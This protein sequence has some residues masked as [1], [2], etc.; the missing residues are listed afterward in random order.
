MVR[1]ILLLV[2]TA[3]LAVGAAAS[4][5]TGKPKVPPGRDPGG[6]AVA[7]F[8]TGI[9][10]TLPPVAARLARDG[11][12]EPIAWDFEDNDN[13]PFDKA[14]GGAP[15]NWGGDATAVASAL[16]S[17]T[18][19]TRLILVRVDP[20]DPISI[21][22]AVVFLSR[23][24]ARLAL[25]PMWSP[26]QQD[27]EPFRQAA[28]HFRNILFIVPAA[29]GPEPVYPAGL[30]LDNLLAVSGAAPARDSAGFGGAMQQL[31]GARLAVVAA[32]AAAAALLGREPGLGAAAL[33][34]RLVASE[35]GT[36]WRIGK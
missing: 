15:V 27:W 34:Q 19:G 23:T 21:G 16:L 32:A 12:G 9:D 22:Q 29:E 4:A 24:P 35:G 20:G 31:S 7:L 25:L 14:R 36:S 8:T 18:S 26:R 6:V 13:R 28:A 2:A 33:K 17:D 1:T 10:F 11:E 30:G 3:Q 5:Q